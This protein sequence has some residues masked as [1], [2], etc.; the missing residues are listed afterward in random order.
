MTEITKYEL[1][2]LVYEISINFN[3]G[4]NCFISKLYVFVIYVIK[5]FLNATT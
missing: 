2:I 3:I 1:E 4:R 5:T